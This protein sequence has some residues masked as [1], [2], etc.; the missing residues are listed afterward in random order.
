MLDD[1]SNENVSEANSEKMKKK[2][3]INGCHNIIIQAGDVRLL[4]FA[5][6]HNNK[7]CGY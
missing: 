2:I 1:Q 7:F 4:T 6:G 3:L 5:E